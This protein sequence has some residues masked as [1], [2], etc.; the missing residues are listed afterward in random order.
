ML[1]PL[2]FLAVI[3]TLAYRAA[4]LTT[5]TGAL[6]VTVLLYGWLGE[7]AGHLVL[8]LLAYLAVFVPL[9]V[10][11]LRQEWFSRPLLD[12]FLARV[13]AL[14]VAEAGPAAGLLEGRWDAPLRAK[15]CALGADDVRMEAL[16][17]ALLHRLRTPTAPAV[18]HAAQA[19][20]AE[21]LYA[22]AAL[23][24]YD[25][26]LVE[27]QAPTPAARAVAALA[28]A[29]EHDTALLRGLSR[30]PIPSV[31]L[32]DADQPWLRQS[33]A[34]AHH[35]YAA[36]ALAACDPNPAQRLA[37]FDDALWRCVGH[38]LTQAAR[39]LVSG[40]SFGRL[41]PVVGS[42]TRRELQSLRRAASGLALA[43]DVLLALPLLNSDGR[44]HARGFDPP[45]GRAY[46]ELATAASALAWH[47]SAGSAKAERPVLLALVHRSLSSFENHLHAALREL[48]HV[49][50]RLLLRALIFP[51]GRHAQVP[52]IAD[53]EASATA[54]LRET[55]LRQ[56]LLSGLTPHPAL[57]ELEQRVEVLHQLEHSLR[58]LQ[59]AQ[60]DPA[61]AD[62]SAR[63][64][65]A[66]RLGLLS[67][68]EARTLREALQ[69]AASLLQPPD[70]IPPTAAPEAP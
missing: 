39:A 37:A 67:E 41:I 8:L 23:A 30:A 69:F 22:A 48:P 13:P 46:L 58:R 38:A 40:L 19:R 20:L 27:W 47:G 55:T 43:T 51:F 49:G 31:L 17:A 4:P 5:A 34:S 36:L 9:N 18:P 32:I 60:F 24:A 7:S 29:W 64:T 1:W 54:L 25:P 65:A 11:A 52:T 61:P 44:D 28:P 68:D 50:A 57:I 66:E 16:A 56:R 45:L 42:D 26:V 3:G 2:V 12:R 59:L 14:P 33:A 10:L 63:V 6:G 53:D 62:E 35:R 70:H 21:G 15:G